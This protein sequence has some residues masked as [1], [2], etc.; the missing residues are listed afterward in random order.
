[1]RLRFHLVLFGLCCYALFVA[2]DL[3]AIPRWLVAVL[4]WGSGIAYGVSGL[5]WRD[6]DDDDDHRPRRRLRSALKRAR[7][8]LASGIPAR[9]VTA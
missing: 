4:G 7:S 3:H 1:M 8:W 6:D 9:R 5:G 2:G